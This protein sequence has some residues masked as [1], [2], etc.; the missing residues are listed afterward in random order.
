AARAAVRSRRPLHRAQHAPAGRRARRPYNRPLARIAAT[1][2][3][4]VRELQVAPGARAYPIRI[5]SGLRDG[6]PHLSALAAGR[7]VA[8]VT[9]ET[10]A[11]LY[12]DRLVGALR[13][14]ASVETILVPDGEAHKNQAS[15]D[16]VFERLLSKRF[17][18]RC[19][20][21]ALGGGVVGDLTGFAAA[22]YQ[23]GVDFVQV[24]TTLLAQVD[25]SVGGKTAINHP[26]GKNMI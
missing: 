25:S 9:N 18:R 26:L 2:P 13:D 23:R 4:N 10:V 1:R 16:L 24:P 22:V 8:V 11:P 17:D 6:D 12:L 14:A 20:L 7:Q 5:G 19:L 21:V 15:L 3:M